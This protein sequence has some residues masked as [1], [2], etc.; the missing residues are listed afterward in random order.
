MLCRSLEAFVVASMFFASEEPDFPFF[1]KWALAVA[2]QA[3]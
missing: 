2:L 3:F 1:F